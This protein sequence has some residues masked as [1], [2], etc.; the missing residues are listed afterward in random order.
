ML[1][2]SKRYGLRAEET[3]TWSGCVWCDT[4]FPGKSQSRKY[5]VPWGC[6]ESDERRPPVLCPPCRCEAGWWRGCPCSRRPERWWRAPGPAWW[7]GSASPA[8]A[9]ATS[10]TPVGQFFKNFV[11][12]C[13]AVRVSL[14]GTGALGQYWLSTITPYSDESDRGRWRGDERGWMTRPWTI[15]IT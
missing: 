13:E 5:K 12:L 8:A 14:W 1:R 6:R 9:P 10:R 4:T 3:Q 7:W 15:I 2:W 11:S